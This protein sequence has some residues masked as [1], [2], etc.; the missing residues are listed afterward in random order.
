MR[1]E[2]F[3][4]KKP[5]KTVYFILCFLGRK[6]RRHDAGQK[7]I[8]AARNFARKV[9]GWVDTVRLLNRSQNVIN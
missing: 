5:K 7:I 8:Q 3:A 9:A 4:S 1:T 2:K 6:R